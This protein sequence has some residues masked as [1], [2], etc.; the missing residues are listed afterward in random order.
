MK[1]LFFSL[2][3]YAL[4][5]D[6]SVDA[7]ELRDAVPHILDIAKKHDLGQT[8]AYAAERLGV[9]D[10]ALMREKDLAIFR[11]EKIKYAVEQVSDLLSAAEIPHIFL[12]GV[13][14]RGLYPEEWMRPSCDVDVFVD[15][16]K[17]DAAAE[18]LEKGGYIRGRRHIYDVMLT[19]VNGCTVE[20]HF[21][22][23]S[24]GYQKKAAEL[25]K[26]V[27][28]YAEA[29]GGHRYRMNGEMSYFYHISHMA[30]HVQTGGCGV[31]PFIDMKLLA[32]KCD[33]A[34]AEAL[35]EEGG[36][37]AFER[38]ARGLA[39]VWFSNG[40][41][42][43]VTEVLEEYVLS[44]EVYGS[45]HNAAAGYGSRSRYIASR[46]FMPY[47]ELKQKYPAL[48]GKPYLMPYYTLRRWLGAVKKKRVASSVD[49]LKASRSVS[50]AEIQKYGTLFKKLE[51]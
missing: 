30:K 24:E 21:A 32:D 18:A 16:D 22:L 6:G 36:L 17:V 37:S 51:L 7:K 46:I 35:L 43:G 33:R 27:W 11:V 29:E 1:R 50:K 26:N 5:E 8:V 48:D 20:L 12:K 4:W 28:S 40:R 10:G 25:L 19:A 49:E 15:A 45:K 31:R 47:S 14:I 2:L 3:R 41:H 42:D 34:K 9:T 13:H 38:A 39:D 44:G 23:M